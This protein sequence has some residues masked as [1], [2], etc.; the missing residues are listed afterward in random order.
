MSGQ[1]LRLVKAVSTLVGLFLVIGLAIWML[2]SSKITSFSGADQSAVLA[3]SNCREGNIKIDE[4]RSI[5]LR[6]DTTSKSIAKTAPGI[7]LWG[8]NCSDGWSRTEIKGWLK[9]KR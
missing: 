4:S 3:Q 2:S 8:Q 9:L 6:R 7:T 5:Y 1:M